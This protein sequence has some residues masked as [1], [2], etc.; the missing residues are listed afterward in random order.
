MARSAGA[1]SA[2]AWPSCS[3]KGPPTSCGDQ[4]A[5]SRTGRALATRAAAAERA[6]GDCWAEVAMCWDASALDGVLAACQ[7][8]HKPAATLLPRC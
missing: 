4:G 7:G 8:Q 3:W 1:C 5:G 6:S 2:A